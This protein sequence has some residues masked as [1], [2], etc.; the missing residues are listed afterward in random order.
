MLLTDEEIKQ[1]DCVQI[2]NAKWDEI[3]VYAP[4]VIDFARAIEAKIEAKLRE[5]KPVGYYCMDIAKFEEGTQ[6]YHSN[7]EWVPLFEHPAPIPEGWISVNDRLPEVGR[8]PIL[9]AVSWVKYGEHEDGT[10]TEATGVDVTDGEYVP[11]HGEAGGYFDSYQ[12]SHGDS[13]YITH[14]MPLPKPPMAAAR[15]E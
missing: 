11:A 1:L 13:Q 2:H 12:G 6:D 10:P 15:S 7:P 8:T 14:W 9:V 5:E 4:S 3:E